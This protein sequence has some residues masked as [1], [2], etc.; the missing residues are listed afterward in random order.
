LFSGAELRAKVFGYDADG[1]HQKAA[2]S[3]SLTISK[4]Q[5]TKPKPWF[6][7]Y[8]ETKGGIKQTRGTVPELENM[9]NTCGGV[10][11]VCII[12]TEI[13]QRPSVWHLSCQS[14]AGEE[15]L[16]QISSAKQNHGIQKAKELA[17]QRLQTV[18]DCM[19]GEL[20]RWQVFPK[21][22][23]CQTLELRKK[24]DELRAWVA[25]NR[26]LFGLSTKYKGG[27]PN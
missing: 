20:E 24:E 1:D 16:Q 9:F 5:I 10:K 4:H 26:K 7:P 6:E 13:K 14:R 21:K 19:G 11:S 25:V 12:D 23:G 2:E 27:R 17:L 3:E 8:L 15:I 22:F 18:L